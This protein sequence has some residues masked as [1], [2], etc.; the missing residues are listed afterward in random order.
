MSASPRE[1]DWWRRGR[2]YLV[3]LRHPLARFAAPRAAGGTRGSQSVLAEGEFALEERERRA[4]RRFERLADLR[5]ASARALAQQ[6][7]EERHVEGVRLHDDGYS[8]AHP[9]RV[10]LHSIRERRALARHQAGVC[11][12]ARNIQN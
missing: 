2:P 8:R 7:V 12:L 11:E 6:G 5:F 1:A 9:A 4:A 3:R 10:D